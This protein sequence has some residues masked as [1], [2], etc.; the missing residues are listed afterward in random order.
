MHASKETG[1]DLEVDERGGFR[2]SRGDDDSPNF[3]PHCG[4]KIDTD[5]AK[6]CPACGKKL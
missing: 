1:A 3:C 4:Y 2:I 6:F 5:G